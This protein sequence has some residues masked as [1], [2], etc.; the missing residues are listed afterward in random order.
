MNICYLTWEYPPEVNGGVAVY[1]REIARAIRRIGH[2]VFVITRTG[3]KTEEKYEDGIYVIRLAPQKY[4]FFN[5]CRNRIP[6][7]V[8]R[9]E[10]GIQVAKKLRQL[11]K[12]VK[13]DLVE[14]PEAYSLGFI[15]YLFYKFPPYVVKLHTPEGIIF[16]WNERENTL[17]IKL[18][19]KMEELWMLRAKRLILITQAM[20][21]LIKTFYGIDI[22]KEVLIRNPLVL[23]PRLERIKERKGFFLFVGRLEFRKGP[24]IL[25]EAI[26]YI[27]E[28]YPDIKFYFVGK[29]CGMK[30]YLVGK[31]KEKKC[32]RNVIFYDCLP[33]EEVL[34]LY[35]QALGCIIPSLWENFS[36]VVVEAMA[37]GCPVIA[38]DVGGFSEVIENEVTGLLFKTGSFLDLKDKLLY[39]LKNREKIDFIANNASVRIREIT[40]P[41][42]IANETL[43]A[44]VQIIQK[45][46]P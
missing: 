25:I 33:W 12:E 10:F 9:I 22:K 46:R 40:A 44:Y 26:P 41:E 28:E 45:R 8:E 39:L 18:L 31:I 35:P 6:R 11:H 24:H 27:I 19:T 15:Y 30:S 2:R 16:R 17:D 23:P 5:F 4:D 21:E 7:T 13:I 34:K 3:K 36:Y 1:I 43:N 42:R 14:S 37:L 20:K 38:P 29:E 32:D